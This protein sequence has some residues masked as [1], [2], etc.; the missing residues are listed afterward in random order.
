MTKQIRFEQLKSACRFCE[1]DYGT[2]PLP[3]CECSHIYNKEAKCTAK[4]CR[5]W[6]TLVSLP[7][8]ALNNDAIK[9]S[10]PRNPQSRV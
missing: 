8:K 2:D 5:I 10:R 3:D 1:R 7:H 4:Y 6:L 9:P